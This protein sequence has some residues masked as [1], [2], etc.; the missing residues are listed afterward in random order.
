MVN[1]LEVWDITEDIILINGCD[2]YLQDCY[3]SSLDEMQLG[4]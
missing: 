1:W 4:L 3:E 2:I